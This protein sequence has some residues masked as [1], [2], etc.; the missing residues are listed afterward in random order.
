MFSSSNSTHSLQPFWFW[1]HTYLQPL[2]TISTTSW[3]TLCSAAPIFL[4]LFFNWCAARTLIFTLTQSQKLKI[5]HAIPFLSFSTEFLSIL[6]NWEWILQHLK[7]PQRRAYEIYI[8]QN[9]ISRPSRVKRCQLPQ[10]RR[11]VV[12]GMAAGEQSGE[13]SPGRD[14]RDQSQSARS[15]R[16]WAAPG[17]R[18]ACRTPSTRPSAQI[19]AGRGA[20]RVRHQSG[21][22]TKRSSLSLTHL[23][24]LLNAQQLKVDSISRRWRRLRPGL[25]KATLPLSKQPLPLRAFCEVTTRLSN[26]PRFHPLHIYWH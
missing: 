23:Q 4:V 17:R 21:D 15:S 20:A 12:D 13:D 24:E 7:K 6:F 2:K 9:N 1:Q 19:P 25:M 26:H 10:R 5:K 16:R 3:W 11:A 18:A 22:K 8:H 14:W